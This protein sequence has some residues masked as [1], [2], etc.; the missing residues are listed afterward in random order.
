MASISPRT[1]TSGFLR[2]A[3]SSWGD[4]YVGPGDLLGSGDDNGLD[5]RNGM[6]HPFSWTRD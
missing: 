3:I 1:E 2:S 5:P 4:S 6:G